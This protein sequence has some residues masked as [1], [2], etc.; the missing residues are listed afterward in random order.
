MDRGAWQVT[1][2]GF[3]K[4]RTLLS[5]FTFFSFLQQ[6]SDSQNMIRL[7]LI[8]ENQMSQV[9]EFGVFLCMGRGQ[10]LGSLNL[11]FNRHLSYLGPV[12]HVLPA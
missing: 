12:S 11:S 2:Y 1:V 7:L 9:N 8:K 3:T 4:S 10:R 6:R 5:D